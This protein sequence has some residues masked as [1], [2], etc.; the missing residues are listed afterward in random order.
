MSLML[1]SH[2]STKLRQWCNCY[3]IDI[4]CFSTKHAILRVRAKT[5]WLTIR[6]ARNIKSKNK[7]SVAYNQASTQ[8]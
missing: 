2:L 6:L 3:E 5:Q 7:D 8:Y 1:L 4:C